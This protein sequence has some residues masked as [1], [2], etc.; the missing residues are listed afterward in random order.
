MSINEPLV[1]EINRLETKDPVTQE[2]VTK[3][4]AYLR[5]KISAD[6]IEFINEYLRKN[7]RAQLSLIDLACMLI[8]HAKSIRENDQ[9]SPHKRFI[10]WSCSKRNQWATKWDSLHVKVGLM[11][12]VA[13]KITIKTAEPAKK[14][15]AKYKVL[16]EVFDVLKSVSTPKIKDPKVKDQSGDDG[17]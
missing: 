4:E 12:F 13:A 7:H 8:L 9:A 2:E 6:D 14:Q 1:A 17:A 15:A 10:R 16:P 5:P 11:A 3:M